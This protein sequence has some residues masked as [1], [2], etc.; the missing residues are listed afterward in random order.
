MTKEDWK[1][2]AKVVKNRNKFVRNCERPQ[3]VSL[4]IL[5][6]HRD[7]NYYKVLKNRREMNSFFDYTNVLECFDYSQGQENQN[8]HSSSAMNKAVSEQI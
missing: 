7:S 3:K 6:Y 8:G 1:K 5:F 2:L 4:K